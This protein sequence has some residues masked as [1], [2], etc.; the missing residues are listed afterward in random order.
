MNLKTGITLEQSY[1]LPMLVS[2]VT[3]MDY[4]DLVHTLTPRASLEQ[5]T[6]R[7]IGTYVTGFFHF[8]KLDI[9]QFFRVDFTKGNSV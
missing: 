3:Y 9:R 1:P 8:Q 2:M 6:F 5:V 4:P 7:M